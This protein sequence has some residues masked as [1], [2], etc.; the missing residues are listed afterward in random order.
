MSERNGFRN[1]LFFSR[2][3]DFLNI[4]LPSQAVRSAC[5][6]KTYLDGLTAFLCWCKRQETNLWSGRFLLLCLLVT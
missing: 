3:N 1:D 6:V 4:Y 2:T 5:T